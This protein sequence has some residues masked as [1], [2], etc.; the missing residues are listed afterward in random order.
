MGRKSD[1]GMAEEQQTPVVEP[2][3]QTTATPPAEAQKTETPAE[4][5]I[6][7]ARFDEVNNALKK[8]QGD[9]AEQAKAAAKAEEERL[10]H[11]AEWQKLY[12]GSK[13]KV[14][15]LTP[16]A[17]LADKL[18]EM[19]TAQY[20]AEIATWP[21]QVKAMQPDAEA[22][23]LTKL[24][25]MSKAKPLAVELMAD[26][27]PTPG[28]GYRPKPSAPAGTGATEKERGAQQQKFTRANF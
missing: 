17:E 6:P 25:W 9:A 18:T 7:K 3:E 22:D 10:A 27:T 8:L 11:Q 19:V 26:K 16:K 15:E 13:A 1:T 24:A 20:A 5:M 28:N 21:E 14:G 12:E 4:V 2:S 23:I